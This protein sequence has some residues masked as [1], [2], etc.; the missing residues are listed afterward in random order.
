MQLHADRLSG[1]V[2]AVPT[3]STDTAAGAARMHETRI[4][5]A[6]RSEDGDPQKCWWLTRPEVDHDPEFPRASAL[7]T[8]GTRRIGSSRSIGPANHKNTAPLQQHQ[9]QCQ[10]DAG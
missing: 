1:K 4:Y 10:L 8:E 3:R 6:H 2:R 7:F 9:R 5:M